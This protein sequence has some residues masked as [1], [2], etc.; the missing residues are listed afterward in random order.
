MHLSLSFL[1]ILVFIVLPGI[2]SRRFYFFGDFSKE[3]NSK[4]NLLSLVASSSIPGLCIFLLVY[5]VYD[6]LFYDVDLDVLVKIYKSI[7]SNKIEGDKSAISFKDLTN[8]NRLYY[9]IIILYISSIA[10]GVICGRFVRILR[11][12]TRFKLFRFNNYWFYYIRGQHVRFKKLKSLK[13]KNKK[14]LFTHA[15]LLIETNSKNLLYSGFIVDYEL[16][17]LDCTKL[18]K[19]ILKDS[20]RYNEKGIKVKI[21]GEIFVVDCSHLRNV[22]FTYVYEEIKNLRK[23][24]PQFFENILGGVLIPLIILLFFKLSIVN[25]DFYIDYFERSWFVKFLTLIT[26]TQFI[27]LFN[28]YSKVKI[29]DKNIDS[30]SENEKILSNKESIKHIYEYKSIFQDKKAFWTRIVM[31]IVFFILLYIFY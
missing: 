12:D 14:H 22:N 28:P 7:S 20:Y 2:F 19:V 9:F 17:S 3:F 16:D 18:S 29:E 5:F 26:I 11:I 13:Q 15:D 6:G 4:R 31:F 27:S 10:F 25:C 24:K 8:S 1:L 23:F 30:N 21:P